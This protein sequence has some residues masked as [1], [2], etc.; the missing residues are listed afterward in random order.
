MYTLQNY[1]VVCGTCNENLGDEIPDGG[2][3]REH[4]KTHPDHRG[5]YHILIKRGCLRSNDWK[6]QSRLGLPD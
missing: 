6:R 1:Y 2:N 4:M 3:G 5:P